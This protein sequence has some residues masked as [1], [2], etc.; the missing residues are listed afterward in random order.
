[1]L[2]QSL[3]VIPGRALTFENPLCGNR[4]PSKVLDSGVT[5]IQ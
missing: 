4:E 3:L 1:M 5:V 2:L